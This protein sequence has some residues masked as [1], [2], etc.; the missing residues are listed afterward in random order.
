MVK[1]YKKAINNHKYL[2][3]KINNYDVTGL[4]YIENQIENHVRIRH[5]L[6][7]DTYE[8]PYNCTIANNEILIKNSITGNQGKIL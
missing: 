4:P 6:C 8:I 5:I 2:M 1:S 3:V 7:Y